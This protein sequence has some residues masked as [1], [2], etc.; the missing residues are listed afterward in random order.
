MSPILQR[1]LIEVGY[2]LSRLGIKDPPH[3]LNTKTWKEAYSKF[4]ATFGSSKTEDE[5]RNSLKN[6]RDHFDSH[7]INSRTGWMEDGTPQELSSLNKEIFDDLQNL[8]DDELWKR[9]K[10]YAVNSYNEE[11][12]NEK[13]NQVKISQAKFF[14][15]EFS[16]AKLLPKRDAIEIK[17]KHGFVVDSLK[18]FLEKENQSAF[19]YNTQK[20]DLAYEVNG[21]LKYIYEVKT[22]LDT[23]SIYT[24]VGQ[25]FMHTANTTGVGKWIVLPGPVKNEELIGCLD[26]L[27]IQILWF[28]IKDGICE[29][30]T[31]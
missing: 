29:F 14:S 19:L 31:N 22:S 12:A 21:V 10:H 26:T 30:I 16:G 27:H 7:L 1:E 11:L 9:I 23:H 5:F 15:S 4:Y 28:I 6:L 20:I 25:L 18:A 8:S 24:A 13:N 2:F 17:V 3:Q